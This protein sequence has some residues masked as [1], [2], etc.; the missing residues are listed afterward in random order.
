MLQSNRSQIPMSC[1]DMAGLCRREGAWQRLVPA[2]SLCPV[3]SSAGSWKQ[4]QAAS[5]VRLYLIAKAKV[6]ITAMTL[7]APEIIFLY[8]YRLKIRCTFQGNETSHR[9]LR[10]SLLEPIHAEAQLDSDGCVEVFG[11]CAG[12]VPG[13]LRRYIFRMFAQHPDVP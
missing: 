5:G 10:V 13:Y 6:N 9:R 11:A 1:N 8:R 12:P 2:E 4:E 7:A 3:R